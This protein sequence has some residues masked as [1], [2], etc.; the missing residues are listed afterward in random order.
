MPNAQRGDE[1]DNTDSSLQSY[2]PNDMSAVIV[3]VYE[4]LVARRVLVKPAK[5]RNKKSAGGVDDEPVVHLMSSAEARRKL[6]ERCR[7]F[8]VADKVKLIRA[9]KE[10]RD[11]EIGFAEFK[12]ARR[13]TFALWETERSASRT[14]AAIATGSVTNP[15][16]VEVLKEYDEFYD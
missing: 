4:S 13:A 7:A 14:G 9:L 15:V 11:Y 6:F 3:C 10:R 16:D 5:S 8:F 1:D 2:H 12:A